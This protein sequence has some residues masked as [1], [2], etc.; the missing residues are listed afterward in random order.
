VADPA[1]EK[2]SRALGT[3]TII[4][5]GVTIG[6]LPLSE[7]V[8][9]F[10]ILAVLAIFC[11][12]MRRFLEGE[13]CLARSG[14]EVPLVAFALL[15]IAAAALAPHRHSAWLTAG[16]WLG[17]FAVFALTLTLTRQEGRKEFLFSVI[18]A[19]AAVVSLYGL[20]QY[21]YGLRVIEEEFLRDP[22]RAAAIIGRPVELLKDELLSRVR[23]GRVFS[24]FILSTVLAGYL[25]LLLPAA[26]G[27]WWDR[28][29]RKASGRVWVGLVCLVMFSCFIV[30]FA[31]SPYLILALQALL[32]G[33]LVVR[34]QWPSYRRLAG[35][36]ALLLLAAGIVGL[37]VIGPR[38]DL[39][40]LG[41][42][43]LR[44]RL[45][46]WR[47]GWRMIGDH[48]WTGIGLNNFVDRYPA[49][50]DLYARD[51]RNAHSGFLQVWAEMGVVGFVA[52]C[53]LWR[54][55]VVRALRSALGGRAAAGTSELKN[56][57][58]V[59]T[60]YLGWATGGVI[61]LLIGLSMSVLQFSSDHRLAV[62]STVLFAGVWLAVFHF[63]R[64]PPE[65]A[66]E[67]S[68]RRIGLAVGVI[69]FVLHCLVDVDL[70][71][72]NLHLTA[73]CVLALLLANEA[74]PRWRWRL[75]P[76]KKGIFGAV[77]IALAL[78]V[79]APPI[80]WLHFGGGPLPRV[81][82]NRELSRQAKDLHYA[83]WDRLRQARENRDPIAA[84]RFRHDMAKV[85]AAYR[86]SLAV[87]P[88]DDSTWLALAGCY[89]GLW[90]RR[91]SDGFTDSVACLL[92][93]ARLNPHSPL[94]PERLSHLFEAAAAWEPRL[95]EPMGLAVPGLRQS[96]WAM[97]L[98]E[99]R[100]DP[101]LRQFLKIEESTDP[102]PARR[103]GPAL[104]YAAQ[105]LLRSPTDVHQRAR[106]A[107][108]AAQVRLP[109][110]ARE[111]A[112]Q[113]LRMHQEIVR[114][115]MPEK[116]ALTP[117][118]LARLERLAPEP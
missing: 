95:V 24:T 114:A 34:R 9:A 112:R 88:L 107:R 116:F 113:A 13:V 73:W 78:L 85:I 68:F 14:L 30:T 27:D 69:G 46:Y 18:L 6:G 59:G 31:K 83:A 96:V 104:T 32:F 65:P 100:R 84:G 48:F 35:A 43:S 50:K 38:S 94:P 1:R 82:A 4:C 72:H 20:Y 23:G 57:P 2:V 10:T 53:A 8:P 49:Y 45:G 37:V 75:G 29:R 111:Q 42:D 62:V 103:Y 41:L 12:A 71:Q 76:V 40:R 108:L 97:M 33:Y 109:R 52:F 51:V 47:A 11:W 39:F 91:G 63:S 54:W 16:S 70:Y 115:K 110:L 102:F 21:A 60:G 7:D 22:A 118:E 105:A 81:L 93:A 3:V 64:V 87:N 67:V 19:S 66:P 101:A 86:R 36:I 56:E 74:E 89:Q 80:S 15:T 92:Q 99:L 58:A 106:L 55:A 5:L 79:A 61:F 90:G 17:I 28:M 77:S 98:G 44:V 25:L 26:V 117:D